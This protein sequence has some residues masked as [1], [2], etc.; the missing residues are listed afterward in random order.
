[1]LTIVMV[2][3]LLVINLPRLLI[4]F[5][6]SALT[7]QGATAIHLNISEAGYS[8]LTFDEISFTIARDGQQFR[9]SSQDI[10]MR[11]TLASLLAGQV[12][13]VTITDLQV[14][15]NRFPEQQQGDGNVL[16][17]SP[18]ILAALPFSMLQVLH[19]QFEILEQDKPFWRA[20]IKG[21]LTRSGSSITAQFDVHPDN[22]MAQRIEL[23]G[24]LYKQYQLVVSSLRP[25]ATVVKVLQLSSGPWVFGD[26]A[27]HTELGLDINIEALWPLLQEWGVTGLPDRGEGTLQLQGGLILAAN[28]HYDWQAKGR[29]LL[30]LPAYKTFANN[31]RLD[32]PIT[33]ALNPQQVRWQIASDAR[34]SLEK[35][36]QAQ[37]RIKSVA[38]RIT[39]PVNCSYML[40]DSRWM[41]TSFSLLSTIPEIKSSVLSITSSTAKLGVTVLQGRGLDWQVTLDVDAPL[42]TLSQEKQRLK[43][44]RIAGTI[45]ASTTTLEGGLDVSA[46]DG[47]MNV[48]INARHQFVNDS[49]Q[50]AFRLIPLDLNEHG[51]KLAAISTLWPEK[52]RL[53]GGV[54]SLSGALQWAQGTVL[55][56]TKA[57]VTLQNVAGVYDEF[58][59]SGLAGILEAQGKDSLSISSRQALRLAYLDVGTPISDSRMQLLIRINKQTQ[60]EFLVTDLRMHA[61]GGQLTGEKIAIDLSRKANPFTLKVQGIDME[62]FLKLEQKQG[63][64]GTGIIDGELPLVLTDQGIFMQNGHLGARKPG[65]ILRYNATDEVRKLA[66]TN[67]S[68]AL[69]V[70]AMQHFTYK[71]LDAVAN[72]TPDGLLALK[73]RIEGSN[74]ELE[75]GRP[76]HLNVN[77]EN[78][79]LELLRSLRLA[80]EI[81][82]NVGKQLQKNK[83]ASQ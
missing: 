19:A 26:E 80:D 47:A 54:V 17:T 60:P 4:D 5:L 38:A 10:V 68:V 11:Y 15:I 70:N 51:K 63:L 62:E 44:D 55:P 57:S 71:V 37:Y 33:L 36:K 79:V 9:I 46:A 31:L 45:M 29:V 2:V 1:M 72:F 76:V 41:C 6:E 21:Q 65:G 42:V 18:S 61:L 49:G 53:N 77:I 64:L 39:S 43:L 69:L 75:G 25:D 22:Y 16:L 28:G 23:S 83:P 73:V 67:A 58:V 27:L 3:S 82:E 48:H 30:Q 66:R 52:L 78:N 50:L 59:F 8:S 56:V 81:G 7:Q 40:K 12:D 35:I 74:P 13:T 32:M 20:E 34:L 14:G 24:T